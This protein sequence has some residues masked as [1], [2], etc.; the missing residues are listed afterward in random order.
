MRR[1]RS[2]LAALFLAVLSLVARAGLPAA[3]SPPPA[4]P[5]SPAPG[6]PKEAHRL[7][8]ALEK[9][10]DE[11]VHA[12][13]EY[14]GL[15]LK[16]PVPYGS[17]DERG[18]QAKVA[19][20]LAEDLPAD[21]MRALSTSLQAFGLVP[22]GADVGKIYRDLLVQQVA[23]Y[24]DPERKY[25]V[26]VERQGDNSAEALGKAFG[27]DLAHRAEEGI[28][29]HELT[30][31]LDDQHFDIAK[32][33]KGDPLADGSA[34]YLALVE[35]SATVTMFDYILGKRI[36]AVPGFGQVMGSMLKDPSQLSAFSP[37]L[38]GSAGLAEAPAWFRD[39]LIFSYLQGFS[40]CLDVE[41]AGGQRLLDHAFEK[42]PPRSTE[43]ILHPEKWHG[44][45]DDPIGLPWP[46]LAAVLPGWKKAAEGEMGE[47]GIGIL[48]RQ[49]LQETNLAASAAAG[50][51]G[52]RFAVYEKDGRRLLLWVT[53]WDTETDAA[54]FQ[55]TA[56]RLPQGEGGW[57]LVRAAPTR[58]VLTRGVAHLAPETQARVEAA[59]A[60]IQAQR[61]ANKDIDLA[62]LGIGAK[63]EPP[64]APPH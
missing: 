1:T 36:E 42:D 50:W 46:D 48:L 13:E 59:L 3:P 39:T 23:A 22:R 34:A 25:L 12:A 41:H 10:M 60:A 8:P 38:P 54:E 44:R 37:D 32:G 63:P 47:E 45:R 55:S 7:S 53:E 29:V 16:R 18:L 51:G 21:E 62:A 5:A 61:P 57:K 6:L 56:S 40:F 9:H 2:P 15:R 17:L 64:A 43:Q 20:T 30:H 27:A 31:A 24:Y 28:L 26:M 11:L 49:A 33:S 14:R 19:E 58:V 35:G 4:S 52:D